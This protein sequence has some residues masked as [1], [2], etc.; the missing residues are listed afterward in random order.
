MN[1]RSLQEPPWPIW[2]RGLWDHYWNKQIEFAFNAPVG[3][4]SCVGIIEDWFNLGWKNWCSLEPVGFL[5]RDIRSDFHHHSTACSFATG[6]QLPLSSDIDEVEWSK[7]KSLPLFQALLKATRF[8]SVRKMWTNCTLPGNHRQDEATKGAGAICGHGMF[9]S[10][11]L[12]SLGALGSAISSMQLTTSRKKNGIS[13]ALSSH[14][15]L[16]SR[17]ESRS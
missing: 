14:E 4:T 15:D 5:D 11:S 7:R 12:S 8:L 3:A 17:I 13:G 10:G 1:M 16:D 2:S 6:D 9:G